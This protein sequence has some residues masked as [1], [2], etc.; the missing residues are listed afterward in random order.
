MSIQFS[1]IPEYADIPPETP[2]VPSLPD[3]IWVHIF[4]S[5]PP[6]ER[7][8][9]RFVNHHFHALW[10][11]FFQDSVI[12]PHSTPNVAL[13]NQLRRIRALV[14]SQNVNQA[15]EKLTQPEIDDPNVRLLGFFSKL[16]SLTLTETYKAIDY[17]PLTK[18]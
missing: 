1:K 14:L 17:T 6:R 2:K 5:I 18:L 8:P 10:I 16:R 11:E 15:L 9:L 4:K 12:V 3:E 13:L 7:A